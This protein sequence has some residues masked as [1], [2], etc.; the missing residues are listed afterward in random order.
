MTLAEAM[1][2]AA[3]ILAGSSDVAILCHLN[4]DPDALGSML[5]LASY[6]GS[7]GIVTTCS[8]PNEPL[9]SPRWARLLPGSDALV[10]M[11]RF[12]DPPEVLV[13][14]DCAS[15]DRLGALAPVVQRASEVIWIDHHRSN[16]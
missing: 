16:D 14:C 10:P 15:L 12:P 5:G 3:G 1:D 6:L 11:K 8:F 13:T 4:P 9:D 7:R 2:K